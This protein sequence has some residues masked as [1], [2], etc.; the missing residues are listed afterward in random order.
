MSFTI[1]DVLTALGYAGVGAG[2]GSIGAALVST[3]AGKGESRAHAAALISE[4]AAGLAEKQVEIIDRITQQNEKM[5]EAIL[6]LSDVLDE[7]LPQ[8]PLSKEDF[9]KLKK[10]N[11]TAKSAL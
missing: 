1:G 7:L 9:E 11:N 8:L 3:R 4:A 10:A 5:R 2:I 6:L